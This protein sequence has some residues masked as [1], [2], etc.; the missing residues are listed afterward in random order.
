MT[1]QKIA[2]RA[3]V[4][5][6]LRMFRELHRAAP[7]KNLFH[8]PA[9]I[10]IALLMAA[11]G[12]A[13][14][15]RAALLDVL[16]LEDADIDTIALT[17]RNQLEN[18]DDST[19]VSVANSL[20]LEPGLRFSEGF[21]STCREAFAATLE[22]LAG[23][24]A[25]INAWVSEHTRGR[26]P[27][28]VD[29]LAML[30]VLVLVNAIY[31]KGTWASPFSPDNSRDDAFQRR[32]GTEVRIP[33]MH[34]LLELDYAETDHGQVAWLPYSGNRLQMRVFLPAP[35]VEVEALL[36]PGVWTN[37]AKSVSSRNVALAMP[38]FKMN[39]K[40]DLGDVLTELGAGVAFNKQRADF[41]AMFGRP[42]SLEENVYI[43]RVLHRACVEVDEQ[44]TEAAA[45]TEVEM[46][47]AGVP[48]PPV[49]LRLDRPFIIAIERAG[50][51][52]MLFAGVV[53]DPSTG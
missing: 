4:E 21:I 43:G 34:A 51:G 7:G 32:D 45:A 46:M 39:S 38:R 9:S 37:A 15:T 20:W 14:E 25:A 42:L 35:G 28:I 24:P 10:A 18:E 31:F 29:E 8:S 50:L 33:L 5:F 47:V 17:L 22:S 40:F 2:V 13:G 30:T 44:G 52:T 36:D 27:S 1:P 19:E 3:S 16:S 53:E 11:A 48:E 49:I 26:I 23:G 6:G 12:A 41:T